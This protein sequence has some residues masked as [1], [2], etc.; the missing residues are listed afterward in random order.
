MPPPPKPVP[1]VV[2]I[3]PTSDDVPKPDLTWK[4]V[5]KALEVKWEM[6]I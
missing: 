6:S 4:D 2:A 3:A 1:E 5:Q